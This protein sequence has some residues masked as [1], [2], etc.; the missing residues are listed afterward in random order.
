MSCAENLSFKKTTAVKGKQNHEGEER[1]LDKSLCGS[2][3]L[4]QLHSTKQPRAQPIDLI[5]CFFP[6][7]NGLVGGPRVGQFCDR[8]GQATP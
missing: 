3:K 7:K 8:V 6:Q 2:V 1:L 4:L 5:I